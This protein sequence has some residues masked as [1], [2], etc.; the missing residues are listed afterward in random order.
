S[1]HYSSDSKGIVFGGPDGIA[2]FWTKE[3][4]R[5]PEVTQAH[6][7]EITDIQYFRNGKT[8]ATASCD[9]LVKLWKVNTMQPLDSFDN[10]SW[11]FSMA[12]SP[13]E[14]ILAAGC[15]DKTI[16]LWDLHAHKITGVIK[17]ENEFFSLKFS[18]DGKMLIA[19]SN[20]ANIVLW[21]VA[22]RQ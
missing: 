10:N 9:G 1:I 22:T 4:Y 3:T 20:G 14:K 12:V 2:R 13:D 17:Y 8:M 11:V 7:A 18:P 19:G 16:K 6:K 21:N 15:L 5:Q